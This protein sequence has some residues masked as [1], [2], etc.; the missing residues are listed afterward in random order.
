MGSGNA[1]GGSTG[2]SAAEWREGVCS[3]FGVVRDSVVVV[4]VGRG[5]QWM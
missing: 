5:Q 1:G 4:A 2:V 3:N